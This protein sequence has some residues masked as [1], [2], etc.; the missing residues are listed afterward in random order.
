MRESEVW[1]AE[2]WS[3]AYGYYTLI[4][5]RQ[6]RSNIAVTVREGDSYSI[7]PL[8]RRDLIQLTFDCSDSTSSNNL[9][10]RSTSSTALNVSF[11]PFRK[12]GLEDRLTSVIMYHTY[13]YNPITAFQSQQIINHSLTVE[14]PPSASEIAP[15]F[16]SIHNALRASALKR[17]AYNR[18]PQPLIRR[19]LA[20]YCYI[21]PTSQ[22]RQQYIL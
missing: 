17:K 6:V 4:G 15:T 11:R 8:Q 19:S 21:L 12:A 10:Y 20:M 1:R 13:S 22:I 3:T 18:H 2:S 7:K 16:D 14:V 5:S 9:T